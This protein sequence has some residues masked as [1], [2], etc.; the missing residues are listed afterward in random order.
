[1][2]PIASPIG[3]QADR[4]THE[5]DRLKRYVQAIKGE[6]DRL[7]HVNAVHVEAHKHL[8]EAVTRLQE[9]VETL[10]GLVASFEKLAARA[11]ERNARAEDSP[12]ELTNSLMT[13]Q[14]LTTDLKKGM[15]AQEATR[16][17]LRLLDLLRNVER[18]RLPTTDDVRSEL[19][20]ILLTYGLEPIDPEAGQAF[21][22]HSHKAIKTEPADSPTKKDVVAQRLVRGWRWVDTR[23]PLKFAEV[24]VY[25]YKAAEGGPA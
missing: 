14:E 4:I 15:R 9:S 8:T 12:S 3:Q 6:T 19:E 17:L 7:Q 21:D 18:N 24:A 22:P 1:M 25:V 20:E 5:T 11:D 10:N 13:L 16:F 2:V 23:H